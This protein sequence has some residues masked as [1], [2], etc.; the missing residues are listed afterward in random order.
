M[1]EVHGD[2]VP[3]TDCTCPS[4]QSGRSGWRTSMPGSRNCSCLLRG[5]ADERAPCQRARA[6]R[7]GQRPA[8]PRPDKPDGRHRQ[9][10]GAAAARRRPRRA[11]ARARQRQPGHRAGQAALLSRGLRA[12]RRQARQSLDEAAQITDAMFH[13]R[14]TVA[15]ESGQPRPAAA[16]GAAQLSS[17]SSASRRACPWAGWCASS[18]PEGGIALAVDGRRTQ[19]PAELWAHVTDGRGPCRAQARGGAVRA[20]A[21]GAR[22]LGPS[23]R[24]RASAR[25][26][27]EVAVALSPALAEARP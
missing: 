2:L 24:R 23:A 20:A 6:Q 18:L 21:P 10:A 13:G 3:I 15:W 4:P 12:G 8:L 7:A 16:A 26:R 22:G 5:L 1:L 27:R 25:A 17:R 9:R 14:F 11:G 19:P